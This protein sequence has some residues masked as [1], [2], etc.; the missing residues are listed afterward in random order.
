MSKISGTNFGFFI[1]EKEFIN[2][3]GIKADLVQK[4]DQK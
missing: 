1:K 3:K 2:G 4:S